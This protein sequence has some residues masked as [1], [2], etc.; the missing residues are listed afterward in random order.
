MARIGDTETFEIGRPMELGREGL[1]FLK[2]RELSFGQAERLHIDKR[3]FVE[4]IILTPGSEKLQEI[5]PTLA[6]GRFK[7]AK[8][9]VADRRRIA[10]FPQVARPGI[11]CPHVAGH[12]QPCSKYLNLFSMKILMPFSQK[13]VQLTTGNVYPGISEV[14]QQQRLGDMLLV[15]QLESVGFQLWVK[16]TDNPLRQLPQNMLPLGGQPTL[17]TK[18][19]VART[20]TNPLHDVILIPFED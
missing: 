9:L 3:F 20:N 11:I 10:I 6:R 18:L 16:M 12:C 19:R 2:H 7:P 14:C 15:M 8:K 1:L 5:D 17:Q 4:D 13:S